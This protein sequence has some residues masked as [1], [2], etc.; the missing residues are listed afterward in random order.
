MLSKTSPL[1]ILNR[2]NASLENEANI[3]L[4]EE[5]DDEEDEENERS[6]SRR[7]RNRRRS[8]SNSNVSFSNSN[9]NNASGTNYYTIQ[10]SRKQLD[11]LARNTAR[12]NNNNNY[13]RNNNNNYRQQNVD[14]KTGVYNKHPLSG[15]L[16]S[17]SSACSPLKSS[18]LKQQLILLSIFNEA[19]RCEMTTPDNDYINILPNEGL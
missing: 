16:F 3:N 15:R 11:S 8:N 2:A 18:S 14:N 7:F 10:Y 19:N 13:H 4:D 6:K 12:L 5:N 17:S 1:N 9:P